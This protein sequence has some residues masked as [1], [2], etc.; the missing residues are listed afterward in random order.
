MIRSFRKVVQKAFQRGAA[1][2]L[3]LCVAAS[4]AHAQGQGL[5]DADSADEP[6][7]QVG[8]F[9]G[10]RKARINPVLE[11]RARPLLFDQLT[12]E[13][14][15]AWPMEPYLIDAT[16]AG[17]AAG[18]MAP[19]GSPDARFASGPQGN[20]YVVEGNNQLVIYINQ[21]GRPCNAGSQGCF[22]ILS[23]NGGAQ[24]IAQ[25][26]ISSVGDIFDSV[27]IFTTFEDY[28]AAAY[29]APL[30]NDTRG[31]GVCNQNSQGQDGLFGCQYDQTNGLNIQGVIFMNSPDIW[32]RIDSQWGLDYADDDIRNQL[33]ATLGQESAHRWLAGF[34]ARNPNGASGSSNWLL[35][36]D[37]SHW[38]LKLDTDGSWMDGIDWREDG[39]GQFTIIGDNDGFSSLDLYGMGLL[40]AEDVAPFFFVQNANSPRLRA[41][42][43]QFGISFSGA[44]PDGTEEL[45]AGMPP[46]DAVGPLGATGTKTE[47][48]I[49]DVIAACGPRLP[50]AEF[51]PKSFKQAFVLV[52]LPGESSASAVGMVDRLDLIRQAWER[53]FV[54]ATRGLGTICTSLSGVCAAGTAQINNIRYSDASGDNNGEW[55]RGETVDIFAILGNTGGSTLDNVNVTLVSPTSGVVVEQGSLQVSGIPGNGTVESPQPFRVRVESGFPCDQSTVTLT[56]SLA[57]SEPPQTRDFTQTVKACAPG[58]SSG[59]SG[60]DTPED[61]PGG[62]LPGPCACAVPGTQSPMLAGVLGLLLLLGARRRRA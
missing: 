36:R 56:V 11:A 7:Y 20:I 28:A 54:T 38:N 26:V 43:Q 34:H 31:L 23:Q 44:I 3:G 61:G 37:K 52:T 58:N 33:F 39:G 13:E 27:V 8:R 51:S 4:T 55:S 12:P 46:I 14:Y 42:Y 47:V 35:G 40:P 59:G 21:N 30:R 1:V 50:S 60:G 45:G 9:G 2:A 22:P 49:E 5:E 10:V 25:E 57:G 41:I 24:R 15:A 53:H 62:V 19:P 17:A 6:V 32:Q 48:T 29:Y 16:Q 18:A